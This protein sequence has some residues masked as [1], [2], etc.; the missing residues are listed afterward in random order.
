MSKHEHTTRAT[1]D[2]LNFSD[3]E[4]LWFIYDSLKETGLATSSFSRK[5]TGD[6]CFVVNLA[7]GRHAGPKVRQKVLEFMAAYREAATTVTS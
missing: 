6:P 5:A 3:A 2:P 1:T 7:A 4:F